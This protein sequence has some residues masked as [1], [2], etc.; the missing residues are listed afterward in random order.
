MEPIGIIHSPFQDKSLIPS[1]STKAPEIE[2]YIEI[3]AKYEAGIM[4]LENLDKILIIF[5]FHK[6]TRADLQTVPKHGT[7]L[8]GIFA[9]R[10]P[11][12][13]NHLGVSIVKLEKIEG[14]I[15]YFS[16]CDMLEGSPVWDI[17]PQI[18]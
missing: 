18:K 5:G 16:G 3:F 6:N 12:R 4:G 13:P 9:T 15:I 2:A 1:Q 7:E 11:Y 8:K 10:S 17:K 14:N